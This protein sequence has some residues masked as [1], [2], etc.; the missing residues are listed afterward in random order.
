MKYLSLFASLLWGTNLISQSPLPIIQANSENVSIRDGGFFTK[1]AWTLSPESKPDVYTAER[2]R[3]PKWVV[4]YTDI[5]SIRTKVK[6]GT[7]F[8]FIILL[9]GKDTCYTRINSAIPLETKSAQ[10]RKTIDTIPFTLTEKNAIHVKAV[11]NDQDT[12]NLHFDIG[13]FDFRITQEAILKKT[14]LLANQPEALAGR[15][16]PNFNKMGPVRKIQMGNAIWNNPLVLPTLLTA[17]EMDGRF[18]WNLFEGKMVE[19]DYNKNLI[20]IHSKLP[21]TLKG[22]KKARLVF[23]Q[24][25]VCI[26]SSLLVKDKAYDGVF[27]MDTGSDKAL[28]VD[29]LWAAKSNFP[30]DLPL[31]KTS[32]FSDPRG[33]KYESKTVLCPAFKINGFK[34]LNVPATL[35]GSKNPVGFE[36]NYL[37]NDVLKRYNILLD[38]KH[39]RIYLKPNKLVDLPFLEVKGK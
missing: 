4:F 29:S 18:G 33:V 10:L 16:K 27:L 13:S 24:S 7:S 5:D 6:P 2:S 32:V 36:V 39:D 20:L 25:F 15:S 34:L 31:L 9:H 11:L 22:Y 38:F 1:N 23:L 28:I 26:N 3:S 19:I 21:K 14:G 37:G 17:R 8:D 35:L 30:K 12:L